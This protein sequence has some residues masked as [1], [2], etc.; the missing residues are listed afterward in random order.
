MSLY[1]DDTSTTKN[2]SWEYLDARGNNVGGNSGYQC[3][4]PITY[5]SIP[6]EVT[7]IVIKHPWKAIP[8]SREVAER[9]ISEIRELGFPCSL[10]P[11]ASLIDVNMRVQVSLSHYE[12]KAHLV[13]ALQLIRCLNETGICYVPDI[14]FGLLAKAPA[15]SV[16]DRFVMLQKANTT[17]LSHSY[18]NGNHM[19][20]GGNGYTPISLKTY[21]DRIAKCRKTLRGAYDNPY[22]THSSYYSYWRSEV[23]S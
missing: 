11:R 17:V 4:S 14:Y 2:V 7:D 22:G 20:N 16:E 8:Y 18:V 19:I 6:T 12:K 21:L 15:A 13:H 1:K 10:R 5:G 3:F 9:W 23:P